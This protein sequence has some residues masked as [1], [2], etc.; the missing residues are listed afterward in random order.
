MNMYAT[1]DG[2]I[3]YDHIDNIDPKRLKNSICSTCKHQNEHSCFMRIILSRTAKKLDE[4]KN[5]EVCNNG[6]QT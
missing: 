1:T 3:D 5:W 6:I 4:C 2:F